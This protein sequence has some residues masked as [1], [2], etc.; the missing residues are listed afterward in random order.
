MR[1][2][3][4][5]SLALLGS[6]SLAAANDVVSLILPFADDQAIVGDVVGT[7]GSTTTYA[8]YCADYSDDSECGI[9]TD[10]LTIAAAPSAF[11]YD[12]QF[13]DYYLRESC[14]VRGTTWV[15]CEVTNS[16][17]DFS[18]VISDSTSM[19]LPVIPVTVTATKT[20]SD[21]EPTSTSDSSSAT[22]TET[23]SDDDNDE[24][25]DS[26]TLSGSITVSESP[27][28]TAQ[29]SASAS[30]S[31]SPT[32]D[33]EDAQETHPDNAAGSLT[34]SLQWV[35]AGAGMAVALAFA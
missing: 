34:G 18:T 26:T 30:T 32:S 15:S 21:S 3:I 20:D 35:V 33:A 7:S 10:G 8:L 31:A 17:S 25:S 2:Q 1:P 28:V 9:P 6:G 29:P 5:R 22:P 11:V 13:D 23:D 12:Y 24:D 16:Q 19:E 4:I 27:S 14:S